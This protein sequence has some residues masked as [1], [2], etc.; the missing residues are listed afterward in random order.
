MTAAPSGPGP[1]HYRGFTITLRHTTPGGLLWT[2]DQPDSYLFHITVVVITAVEDPQER[3]I[4]NSSTLL[5]LLTLPLH[6]ILKSENRTELFILNWR[7]FHWILVL[8]IL[9][10]CLIG[11]N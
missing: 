6:Y 11:T 2:S 5:C 10:T 8:Y 1:P 7:I 9:L 4:S 3:E